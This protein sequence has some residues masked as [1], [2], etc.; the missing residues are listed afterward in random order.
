MRPGLMVRLALGCAWIFVGGSLMGLALANYVE[1]ESF[2]FYR[3]ASARAWKAPPTEIRPIDFASTRP[4]DAAGT[5]RLP[6]QAG[7]HR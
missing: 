5:A 1:T 6:W 7:F 3:Q 2:H 4:L